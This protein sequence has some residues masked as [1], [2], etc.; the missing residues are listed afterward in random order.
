MINAIILKLAGFCILIAQSEHHPVE[1]HVDA[2]S[3]RIV[4][5]DVGNELSRN[6]LA[7][8]SAVKGLAAAKTL[9]KGVKDAGARD[10]Y[11]AYKKTGDLQ[12][13]FKDFQSVKQAFTVLNKHYPY[14]ST[15]LKTNRDY[16]RFVGMVGDRSIILW[17]NGDRYSKG[18]PVLEISSATGDVPDRITYGKGSAWYRRGYYKESY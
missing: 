8:P 18:K 10:K 1:G 2:A 3:Q 16:S 12:T 7:V 4:N 15:S 9:L 14:D 6:K 5:T 17:L 11:H 13:A